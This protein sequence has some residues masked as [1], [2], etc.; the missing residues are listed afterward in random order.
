VQ[1]V[2]LAGGKGSRLR[3]RLGDFPKPM[4]RIGDKPLLEHQILLAKRYG[5][6]SVVLLGGYGAD[7]I[8]D[9]F[10]DG[11]RW[12]VNI[13]YHQEPAPL[14]TA[15]AVLEVLGDLEDCFFVMYGD[16]MLNVDLDRFHRAHVDSGAPVSLLVHPNDHP[17]DSDLV[18]LD[19][20]DRIR[21]FHPY[22]HP[23]NRYFANL[24]NAAL[25]VVERRSLEPYKGSITFSDFGKHLFPHLLAKGVA[26]HAYRSREYIKDAG[27]PERLDRVIADFESGRIER[28]SLVT[29]AAGVFLDRDGTL[30]REV[31]HLRSPDQLQLLIA[32]PEAIRELNSAGFPVVVITNQPVIARGECSETVLREIH[33]KLETELGLRGAYLDGIYYCP[34]HPDKGYEGERPELK[35]KCSCRKPA[36]G[37]IEQAA[38]DLNLDLSQSWL[39]G[40]TSR[41]IQTA[42]NAGLRSIL[43]QT[44]PAAG[45]GDS[46]VAPDRICSDLLDAVKTLLSVPERS[47]NRQA[48]LS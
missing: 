4:V 37:L 2:V 11:S 3:D 46:S 31:G 23:S 24:V 16:T 34:H 14:G 32:V 28:G 25:Y 6:N 39:I 15:G 35:I 36:I 48:L 45:D 47:G 26:L 17:H 18:E 5:I 29:S 42:R 40:D 41:D 12:S 30:N 10:G 8:R 33:N 20:D 1:L 9:Y 13:V 7:K 43:V 22:P 19:D 44:G 27:T 21:C 38:C